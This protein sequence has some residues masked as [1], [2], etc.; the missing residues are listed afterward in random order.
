MTSTTTETKVSQQPRKPPLADWPTIKILT[1]PKGRFSPQ[2]D[3]WCLTYCS[4]SVNGRFYGK[5]PFCRSVC[6]RR[7]FPHEVKNIIAFK[8]HRN[9][10]PDGK[11]LYPLPSEGQ[12]ANL[13]RIL[14]GKPVEDLDTPPQAT[15]SEPV[16]HWDEGWYL[17]TTQ[18]RLAIHEKTDSMMM[19][20]ERQQRVNKRYEQRRE[21]WQDYQDHLEKVAE[22]PVC[23]DAQRNG[24]TSKWWGPI[25]PPRP[26]PEFRSHSL[27]VPIPPDIP[28]FW[29]R[30]TK[31]LAPSHKAIGIFRESVTSGEQ[32]QFAERVWEKAWS[33]EPFILASRTF[34]RAYQ[35]WKD[36]EVPPDEDDGRK[37]S[38]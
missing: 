16:K 18:S 12:P 8:T 19:D 9:L 6:I 23:D 22:D 24:E 32:R 35:R 38:T 20:L 3:E 7:V 21:V 5:E 14:G 15:P 29:D 11:A 27:L 34:S 36:R 31:L 28:P 1:P 2:T 26:I 25:V 10:N 17:W 4:Q 37:G 33:N 13:P 30:I